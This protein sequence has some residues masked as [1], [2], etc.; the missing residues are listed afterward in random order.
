MNECILSHSVQLPEGAE[1]HECCKG[2]QVFLYS[3]VFPGLEV[4]VTFDPNNPPD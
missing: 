3:Q 2:G 1:M 4:E